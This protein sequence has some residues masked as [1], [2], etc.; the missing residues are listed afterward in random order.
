MER[1]PQQL[2]NWSFLNSFVVLASKR[3]PFPVNE[4]QFLGSRFCGKTRAIATFANDMC[5]CYSLDGKP[6]K[7]CFI[8]YRKTKDGEAEVFKDYLSVFEANFLSTE[9]KKHISENN[10][11][12]IFKNGSALYFKSVGVRKRENGSSVGA[13]LASCRGDYIICVLEECF[14]FSEQEM[15]DIDKAIRCFNPSSQILFVK[16]CNPY[17]PTLPFIKNF[18][19]TQPL[20]INAMKTCGYQMGIYNSV[21]KI[22]GIVR[23]KLLVQMNWRAIQNYKEEPIIVDGVPTGYNRYIAIPNNE[24]PKIV[25]P[26]YKLDSLVEDYGR[27]DRERA[28][29]NDLGIPGNIDDDNIFYSQWKNVKD[30]VW[31]PHENWVA[32]IDVGS[33]ISGK[34]GKTG[35]LWIGYTPKLHGDIYAELAIGLQEKKE[36]IGLEQYELILDF[37][38]Q[39]REETYQKTGILIEKMNAYVDNSAVDFI[40]YINVRAGNGDERII[41]RNIDW[42]NFVPCELRTLKIAGEKSN[43]LSL[44]I[45]YLR[46]TCDSGFWR[47]DRVRCPTLDN[48]MTT[49]QWAKDKSGN[50]TTKMED[51]KHHLID[52]WCYGV[53]KNIIYDE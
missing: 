41:G 3:L 1:L 28:M 27:I 10:R 25:V 13:G 42:I 4:L 52:A 51:D 45:P 7:S 2:K 30:A 49:I 40:N 43:I 22:T 37:L 18:Y 20:D 33:G 50:G 32:G 48:E 36:I 5:N 6:V 12:I 53:E 14:E 34:S 47:C 11:N 19:L 9:Y 35:I 38:E 31:Y 24:E 16:I 46:R 23:K 15:S 8:I 21:D 39:M 26:Q 17:Y 44:R 29:V